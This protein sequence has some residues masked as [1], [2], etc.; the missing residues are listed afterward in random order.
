MSQPDYT[1]M[2]KIV[3]GDVIV[4]CRLGDDVRRIAIN[5]A[6][7]FDELCLMM[8]RVFKLPNT[9]DI[10]LKYM[11]NENDLISLLDDNDI[12]QALSLSNLLKVTV[13]DKK[14][15]G[16]NALT[17]GL[18]ITDDLKNQ[19]ASLRDTLDT[20][21]RSVPEKKDEKPQVHNDPSYRPLSTAELDNTTGPKADSIPKEPSES[22]TPTNTNINKPQSTPTIK[23]NTSFLPP[24]GTPKQTPMKS[25]AH[26]QQ[27]PLHQTSP[28]TQR[29]PLNYPPYAGGIPQQQ[30][31]P[32]APGTPHNVY[33]TTPPNSNNKFNGPGNF[34]N[35]R[36]PVPPMQQNQRPPPPNGFTVPGTPSMNQQ[37]LPQQGQ[38]QFRPPPPQQQQQQPPP[39]SQGLPPQQNQQQPQGQQP[40]LQQQP[41]GQ[42]PLQQQPQGQQGS[43][44]PQQYYSMPGTNNQLPPPQTPQQNFRPPP[45]GPATWNQ[46]QQQ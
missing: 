11:D 16:L 31:S 39:P 24:P 14:T 30:H 21:L 20:I 8:A 32:S 45:P 6:P 43:F 10:T 9:E 34:M 23:N 1:N 18:V 5:Q 41:Q 29:P 40:P 19:L 35:A 38:Q 15:T 4:K 25:P 33:Q 46:Q 2:R 17:A 12:T 36:P 3:T 27:P 22:L 13:L 28:Y 26:Q 37:Q 7:S 42:P 44:P